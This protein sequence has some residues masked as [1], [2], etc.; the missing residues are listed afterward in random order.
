MS[1]THMDV[2]DGSGA[3][4]LSPEPRAAGQG[5]TGGAEQKRRKGQ[6]AGAERSKKNR[7]RTTI[8]TTV[9]KM[10]KLSYEDAESNGRV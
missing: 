2:E 8:T 5:G 6:E 3:G 9:R 10:A 1:G 7:T 4:P